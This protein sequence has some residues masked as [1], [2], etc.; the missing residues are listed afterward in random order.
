[1]CGANPVTRLARPRLNRMI[2][3]ITGSAGWIRMSVPAVDCTTGQQPLLWP[4]VDWIWCTYTPT[5]W[6]VQLTLAASAAC[7]WW[8]FRR[9][10]PSWGASIVYGGFLAIHYGL[11]L[12]T[13]VNW[14]L[15]CLPLALVS[16]L[17]TAKGLLWLHRASVLSSESTPGG[18]TKM[19]W[20]QHSVAVIASAALLFAIWS[21]THAPCVACSTNRSAFA[22]TV[23]EAGLPKGMHTIKVLG[24]GEV[25]SAEGWVR[26]PVTGEARTLSPSQTAELARSLDEAAFLNLDTRAI[27]V[28]INAPIIE[29]SV[30]I[31][32]KDKTL[33]SSCGG[34]GSRAEAIVVGIASRIEGI[35]RAVQ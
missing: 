35:A 2:G 32:G 17:T 9:K 3:R 33:R 4:V 16:A 15:Y 10:Q 30:S 1:M 25:V 21:P 28:C 27:P 20:W 11:W 6:A 22:V 14:R 8:A 19:A 31:W 13:R 23:R 7:A 12:V 26:E 5:L 24:S 34:K 18:E 29:V